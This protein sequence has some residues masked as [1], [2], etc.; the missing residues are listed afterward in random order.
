MPSFSYYYDLSFVLKSNIDIVQ[1]KSIIKGITFVPSFYPSNSF[2]EVCVNEECYKL[3]NSS[4]FSYDF[5]NQIYF[6]DQIETYEL[7]KEFKIVKVVKEV[8]LLNAPRIYYNYEYAKK[9]LQNTYTLSNKSIY[10]LIAKSKATDSIS[11]YQMLIKLK[12]NDDIIKL[13][14]IIEKGINGFDISSNAYLVDQSFLEIKNSLALFIMIFTIILVISNAAILVF[15]CISLII[16]SKKEMAILVSMGK[17]K[18]SYLKIYLIEMIIVTLI[19]FVFAIVAAIC[20]QSIANIVIKKYLL[21]NLKLSTLF[22]SIICLSF[23]LV[24]II[25]AMIFSFNKI[26]KFDLIRML[27]DE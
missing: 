5:S 26:S 27:R 22:P 1:D 24:I 6:F 14:Q 7:K 8:G 23:S 9:L 13:Y 25:F 16:D 15:I 11:S 2:E 20:F 12:S 18:K 19:A 17:R 21:E 4:A 3:L 10:E